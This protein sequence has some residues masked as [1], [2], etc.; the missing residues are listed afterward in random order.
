MTHGVVL[1]LCVTFLLLLFS[2]YTCI[3][4]HCSSLFFYFCANVEC[5]IVRARQVDDI[6]SRDIE[7]DCLLSVITHACLLKSAASRTAVARQML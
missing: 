1:I 2:V 4:G 6:I 5:V 3:G 7:L